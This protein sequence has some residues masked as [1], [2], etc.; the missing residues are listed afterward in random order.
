MSA[1]L[2]AD[3]FQLDCYYRKFDLY[4]MNWGM[5]EGLESMTVSGAPYG[6]PIAV[7]NNGNLIYM[8]WS[9][10]EQLLCIQD[11]GDVLV[12]D[13]FGVYQKT[14][15]MGQ[16]ARDTKVYKAQLFSNPHGTGLAVITTSN[17]MF[18]LSN[19]S[20]PR[21]RSAPDIPRPNEPITAWCVM[22]TMTSVVG[23]LVCR[24]KEIYKCQ[25]GESRAFIMRPDIKSAYTQILCIVPSHNGKHVVLFTDSGI[26]WI[27]SADFQSTY[28][29][30][31][32]GYLKQPKELVWCD[33]RA[34]IGHW[35]NTMS[36]YGFN[37]QSVTYPY[38][39]PF[40]IIS[41]MDCVRV[42]SETTH[43]LIQKV[44]TVIENIFRINSTAPE[45]YLV[46]ASKQFQ[47]RC[48][49]ADEYIR[50]VKPNLQ[51]A[52]QNCIEAATFE[53]DPDIQKTLIRAA[54]FGKSFII[55]PILTDHYVTICRKLR[56]LNAIRDRKVTQPHL[57]FESTA[58]EI[59]EKLRHVPGVLYTTI[60]MKAAEKGRKA[61]A[62]K[63]SEMPLSHWS[64]AKYRRKAYA[65][66]FRPILEYE[67]RS[68]L[69]VPLLLSLG[70]GQIALLKATASGD[71][72]LVYIV[73]LHLK[74]K[75]GK[76]E[77][78]LTI[79]GFPLAHAL[80]IKYCASH[81]R[82]ALRK[83]Y[84]QEDDFAG[85]AATHIRDAIEMTSPGSAEASLISARECYKKGKNDLGA[86]ICEDARKLCKQQSSLQETYGERFLGLSLHDTVKKLLDQGEVKLADKLRSEYKMP[87]YR[88]WWLRIL[89]LAEK[90]DWADLDKF[91][92][93]RKSP[94]GYEPF[95]DACLKHNKNDEALKY[96]PKCRDDIKVKYYVKAKFF[97]EAAL[98]A[99]ERK[100]ERALYFVR[101]SC[102]ASDVMKHEKITSLLEQMNAKK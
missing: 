16:E 61:L 22:S 35:D 25:L 8:G 88:Y 68:K 48:H 24:D 45:S 101:S 51:K 87:D 28:T 69:Q 11:T 97:E 47:R 102:P 3:W 50:L 20:E 1:L 49:R 99:F 67:T 14:F 42:V 80:Y 33:Y 13:M 62:I 46:E 90:G 64:F 19:V 89:T 73:L 98:V 66:S 85:Q 54:Q 65:V 60:A 77:F 18:L 96:L 57:D 70:E 59:G 41:E 52:V 29:E 38:D 82:E 84:V 39:G 86:S 44:P 100:D 91:S 93:S 53:F 81:N 7:W 32:T 83:V 6:G 10:G 78:E 58:R 76:H 40:H 56:V 55:D 12:Y 17:R 92:K 4:S 21:L 94:I 36:I 37:G 34:V 2:T 27:G 30:I 95:V 43:E 15:S 79:R 72:D 74:E 5:D 23:F 26:L 75:M 9:D 63:T 31:D 71:T